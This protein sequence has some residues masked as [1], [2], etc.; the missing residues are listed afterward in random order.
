MLPFDADNA[1][2]TANN[3]RVIVSDPNHI[4]FGMGRIVDTDE[5]VGRWLVAIDFGAVIELKREHFCFA[6]R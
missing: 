5:A 4:Y 3:E 2:V 6:P 1:N